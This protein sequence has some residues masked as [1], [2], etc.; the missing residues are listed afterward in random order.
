MVIEHNSIMV[1]GHMGA[2]LGY[3][4]IAQVCIEATT[5]TGH[6]GAYPGVGAMVATIL[7][8]VVPADA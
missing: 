6:K 2:Y 3:S 4:K 1:L 5:L 7:C 8:M